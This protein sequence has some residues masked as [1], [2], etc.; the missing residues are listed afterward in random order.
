[1][2]SP[3]SL[4]VTGRSCR[5]VASRARRHPLA[6]KPPASARAGYMANAM[7]AVGE[8]VDEEAADELVR[9]E[10]HLPGRVAMAIA[11]RRNAA[12][13]RIIKPAND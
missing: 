10:R 5:I 1:M 6:R 12:A 3:N 13:K 8:A 4:S 11:A 7:E 9:I 2:S